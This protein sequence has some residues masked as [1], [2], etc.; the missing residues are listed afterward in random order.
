MIL[1]LKVLLIV[2]M[3]LVAT[4]YGEECGQDPYSMSGC[5]MMKRVLGSQGKP[6]PGEMGAMVSSVQN[7]GCSLPEWSGD[8]GDKGAMSEL[9]QGCGEQL[10]SCCT[11][12]MS[13]GASAW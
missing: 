4:A 6:G 2:A 5:Q 12:I 11:V 1:P 7:M 8:K 3:V 9:F 13:M 10:I